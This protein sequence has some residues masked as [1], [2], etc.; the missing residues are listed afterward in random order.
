[1]SNS[2]TSSFAS[3]AASATSNSTNR[4]DG[5]ST[6]DWSRPRVNGTTFRRTSTQSR[7]NLN[8][9]SSSAAATPY[10][11]PHLNQQPTTSRN[12]VSVGSR[13]NKEEVLS[14]YSQQKEAG[15]VGANLPSC[16]VGPWDANGGTNGSFGRPDSRDAGPEVCWNTQPDSIPLGLREMDDEERQRYSTSVNSPLKMNNPKEPSSAGPG[17][18]TSLS[19]VNTSGVSRPGTRRRE[20][21]D[22]FTNGPLSPAENKTFRN[23]PITNTPPPALL[24]RR[25]DYQD[26]P[27]GKEEGQSARTHDSPFGSLRRTGTGGPPSAGLNPPSASPW[28]A[29]PGSAFGA[30]GAF[31][32]MA[33]DSSAADPGPAQRPAFGSVRSTSRFK[34]ILGKTN[35]DMSPSVKEKASFTGLENLP[36]E[37]D[38]SAKIR[39]TFKTRPNR[40]E[41]NPYDDLM[42][43]AGSAALSAHDEAG[44][45]QMGFSAFSNQTPHHRLNQDPTSPTNTNPYQSPYTGRMQDDDGHDP[46][47]GMQPFGRRDVFAGADHR[48]QNS[49]GSMR[50]TGTGMAGLGGLP[51]WDNPGFG[52]GTP[53]RDR[54]PVSAAFGDPVFS[55][56]GGLQSPGGFSGSTFFGGGSS[57][58]RGASQSRLGLPFPPAM[59]DQ[60]RSDSRNDAFGIRPDPF[61]PRRQDSFRPFDDMKPAAEDAFGLPPNRSPVGAARQSDS[62]SPTGSHTGSASQMPTTQQRQMV[63]PDR[64]RWV[65]RDPH[66]NVQGP[67]SGLE[68]HDWFKAGFF[69]AELQ[70][71]K[72]ED[73]EYEPLA[74]LVR[75]IGN[76]RE[77]FLVPQIGVPHGPSPPS[78]V[79]NPFAAGPPSSAQPPFANSFPSFGTTLTADQQ[80]ALERRKQEEQFLMAQQKEWL[81]QKQVGM[82]APNA[83]YGSHMHSLQHH[84]SAHSLHSQ[85][86]ISSI[87]SPTGYQPSPMQ[88]PIQPPP[89]QGNAF[90]SMTPTSGMPSRDDELSGQ[91]GR[92]GLD[93][94]GPYSSNPLNQ[95]SFS[96]HERNRLSMENQQAQQYAHEQ[97]FLGQPGRNDRLEEFHE[98]R[99]DMDDDEFEE[100]ESLPQPIG[101]H[102]PTEDVPATQKQPPAPIGSSK[103]HTA[104]EPLSLT[105]QVQRTAAANKQA[106]EDMPVIEP[107]PVSASPLPAPA[108][109]R[110]RP[111]VAEQLAADSR[112]AAQTPVETPSAS[113]APWADKT[114]EMPKGPSLK[115]IQAMEA[116]RAAEQEAVLL[117]ARRVQI[118]QQRLAAAQA[119]APAPGLPL[120]ST[121]ATSGSP[122]TPT[123]PS[124][125][126]WSKPAAAKPTTAA[127][128]KTLAQI[129]KEEEARKHRAAAQAAA[130]AQIASLTSATPSGSRYAQMASKVTAPQQGGPAP[131]QTSSQT[132]GGSAWQTVGASG[133]PKT[134]ATVVAA[135]SVQRVVSSTAARPALTSTASRSTSIAAASGPKDKAKDELNKWA[136]AQL[137]GKLNSGT[138]VD[139]F[140]GMIVGFPPDVDLLT[141]AVY[142]SSETL[143]ARRFAEEFIRR[144]KLAEKGIIADNKAPAVENKSSNGGWSEVAKKGPIAAPKEDSTAA[145]FKVVSKKPKKR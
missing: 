118:E 72:Q 14:I 41:T 56:L 17:R 20:T 22:S 123:T 124:G 7:D 88:A 50:G 96:A 38:Q 85:P 44:I 65:Y 77:P 60:M 143:D 3:A 57:F 18:K 51:G 82:R 116:K 64:M 144:Q 139:D 104:D 135:P 2:L 36:E 133:K 61:E 110:S 119:P 106:A 141:E 102:R 101:S 10:I 39:E 1:M 43:R 79:A 54:P 53:G 94:R 125:G 117:E 137:S 24:R 107:P 75:R 71:K 21:S 93:T 115:E 9:T 33:A 95:Q 68:M 6:N 48:A 49:F 89:S 35:E 86:S 19:Q 78:N 69:T 31:G 109:Q 100:D 46:Q 55:P 12:G 37:D 138:S 108:A 66:G 131:V 126:V 140:V 127:A 76:S 42:P 113:L 103:K 112:S 121:W 27:Q 80:N 130:N 97:T 26:E 111:P 145:G 58:G 142:G 30:M 129:Q 84:S 128:K 73:T 99:Q 114:A 40:S 11:P 136:K 23:D 4:R 87:T 32:S 122:S 62:N 34:D 16:F 28:S 74:Q 70:V 134:P 132:V 45:E 91:F 47:S 52:A 29:G 83:S 59:Q 67:W 15:L 8:P 92:M 25:T 63:M 120:T 90:Q 81:A 5:P 13:Y 105:Q 98:L